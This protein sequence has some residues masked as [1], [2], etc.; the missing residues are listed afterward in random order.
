MKKLL[1]V[2]ISVFCLAYIIIWVRPEPLAQVA[3]HSGFSLW[4]F[5]PLIALN[6]LLITLYT[7]KWHIWANKAWNIKPYI[8]FGVIISPLLI[9]LDFINARHVLIGGTFM[10]LGLMYAFTILAAYKHGGKTLQSL[11]IGVLWAFCF[12]YSWEIMYQI[13]IYIKSDCSIPGLMGALSPSIGMAAMFLPV[14][15]LYKPEPKEALVVIVWFFIL[16]TAAWLLSGAN[17]LIYYDKVWIAEP[18]DPIGYT[19]TR[20]SKVLAGLAILGFDFRRVV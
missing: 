15:W 10:S 8:I 7:P 19:L 12:M 18:L 9:V 1:A 4:R 16:A 5:I 2:Y 11:L 20:V 13:V 17:T 6:I 3:N 14:I